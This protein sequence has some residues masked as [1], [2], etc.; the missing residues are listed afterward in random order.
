MP[1]T[2]HVLSSALTLACAA[3]AIAGTPTVIFSSIQALPSSQVPEESNWRFRSGTA[4]SATFHR[5]T[6]SPDGSRWALTA[7]ARSTTNTLGTVI[8][9][10]TGTTSTGARRIAR[11]TGASFEPGR[12]Y[13]SLELRTGITNNGQVIFSGNLSGTSNDDQFCAR[14]H[15]AGP[16]EFLAR[17]GTQV[18]GLPTGVFFGSIIDISSALPDGDALLRTTLSGSAT[19]QALL[20]LQDQST[21]TVLARSGVTTPTGQFAPPQTVNAI[22]PDNAVWCGTGPVYAARLNGP[23]ETDVAIV[24][25]TLTI[26][27]RGFAIQGMPAPVVTFAPLANGLVAQNASWGILG[28]NADNQDW[29]M[30]NGTTVARTGDPIA[31]GEPR[32]F[33]DTRNSSTFLALA[34]T[35]VGTL[36][37]GLSDAPSSFIDCVAV[38]VGGR[39]LVREGDPIDLNGDGEAND[40]V[41]LGDI[42]PGGAVMSD[43]LRVFFI[44]QVRDANVNDLGT[45]LLVFDANQCNDIDFNNDGLFPD[46][47]DIDEFLAVF[48]GAPCQNDPPG[49][50]SIDFNRD[51]LF[52]DTTDIDTYLRVF[53]GGPCA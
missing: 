17:E 10:G 15:P 5:I 32:I 19:G 22:L 41:F 50:D 14:S 49:C 34:P 11:Q 30:V 46:T 16:A 3:C 35:S 12:S 9:A 13:D 39:V 20:R 43:T 23:N 38:I 7:T 29:A 37:V 24:R 44:A 45:A 48:S 42:A 1:H 28:T 47:S 51:E 31:P 53:A 18:P 8:V 25:D 52:P 36:L 26:S 2:V 33:S 21:A 40:N 6:L 4:A 27:Q